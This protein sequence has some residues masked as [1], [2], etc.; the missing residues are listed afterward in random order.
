MKFQVVDVAFFTKELTIYDG[1]Q[2][3]CYDFS[4]AIQ[5]KDLV[6]DWLK[7]WK[8]GI[9]HGETCY[10]NIYQVLQR[11][12]HDTNRIYVEGHYK[13]DFLREKFQEMDLTPPCI[14]NLE[15][16]VSNNAPK[17]AK[18]KVNCPIHNV[19][20]YECTCKDVYTLYEYL[21]NLLPKRSQRITTHNL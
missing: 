14:I 17:L 19:F 5:F 1:S 8:Y 9:R 16:R 10:E 18:F 11:D 3:K 7:G 13:E 21:E 15:D 12:L 20:I 6:P 4:P 2:L